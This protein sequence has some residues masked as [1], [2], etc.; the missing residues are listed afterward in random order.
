MKKMEVSTKHTLIEKNNT[1]I[2]IAT[3]V[4]SALA[5][6]AIVGGHSMLSRMSYQRH[7][8]SGQRTAISQLKEDISSINTLV[9]QYQVFSSSNP[10]ILGVSSSGTSGDQG[11]NARIVLDALPSQYDFPALTS[12][13]E[14]IL[15]G[16]GLAPQG[17]SGSDSQ[18][19]G[20]SSSSS[21]SPQPQSMRFTLSVSTTYQTTKDLLGDFQRSIRPFKITNFD[22]SG[23]N[24][25]L[26]MSLTV[27]TYYQPGKTLNITN[28]EVK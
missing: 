24:S 13:L 6:F 22:L 28:K 19:A 26:S 27:D 5:M 25:N 23:S 4:A 9:G 1:R 21:S 16:R 20:G 12:S 11:S 3:A 2:V 7:V 14:K 15:S 8:A 18:P 10:N 17:I